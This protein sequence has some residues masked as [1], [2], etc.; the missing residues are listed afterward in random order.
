[1]PPRLYTV[2]EDRGGGPRGAPLRRLPPAGGKEPLARLRLQSAVV[3][4]RDC[5]IADHHGTSLPRLPGTLRPIQIVFSRTGNS[6]SGEPSAGSRDRLLHTDDIRD[7]FRAPWVEEYFCRPRRARWFTRP[8][9]STT[10][11]CV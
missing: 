10:S 7:H 9:R 8:S 5:R 3:P 6:V 4:A 11:L 1:M 2:P